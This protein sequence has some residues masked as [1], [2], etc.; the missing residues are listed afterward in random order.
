[1]RER[2]GRVGKERR[3]VGYARKVFGGVNGV[4]WCGGRGMEATGAL[5]LF[6]NLQG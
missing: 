1:L 6:K 3:V 2:A 5:C 4:W